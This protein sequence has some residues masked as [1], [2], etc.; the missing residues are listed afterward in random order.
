MMDRNYSILPYHSEIF[1]GP[2]GLNTRGTP[3]LF[4]I[5][6]PIG[7]HFN[8]SMS[9]MGTLSYARYLLI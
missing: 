7:Y 4:V 1:P 8:G 6:P 9:D 3:H 5:S 2:A